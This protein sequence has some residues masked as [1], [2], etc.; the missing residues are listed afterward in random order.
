M[1]PIIIDI[2]RMKDFYCGLG[3]YCWFLYKQLNQHDDVFYF[4]NASSQSRLDK[5]L[6]NSKPWQKLGINLPK[7]RVWHSI[8][9]DASYFP[10]K[11]SAK[12]VL[13]IH[14]MNFIYQRKDKPNRISRYRKMLQTKIDR[15]DYITFISKYTMNDT[16]KF[17]NLENKKT[18]VIYNGV[19]VSDVD[20]KEVKIKSDRPFLLSIVKFLPKKNHKCLIP[21]LKFM[22]YDIVFAGDDATR[23]GEEVRNFAKENGVENRCHFVGRI[24]E[25]EKKWVL[26]NCKGLV[27]PSHLEGFG[28]PVVEAH[29]YGKPTFLSKETSLPEVGGKHSFYFSDFSPK[30]I[31]E[32]INL[33]LKSNN[34]GLGEKLK[35]NAAR[36]SWEKAAKEYYKIYQSL[37]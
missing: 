23:Y 17:F 37:I 9:Q 18:S 35:E 10:H 27:M 5:K 30:V 6:I 1:Y 21:A 4:G 34:Q 13:T 25:E 19:S 15:A 2:E 36:F 16:K 3:Q 33:G 14:D 28:L 12:I 7:S 22:D 8:H 31:A 24:D 32:T 20:V 26:Q 29:H 11:G